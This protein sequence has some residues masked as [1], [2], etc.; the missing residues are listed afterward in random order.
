MCQSTDWLSATKISQVAAQYEHTAGIEL[1]LPVT[2]Q[3]H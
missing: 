2:V 1:V 3:F